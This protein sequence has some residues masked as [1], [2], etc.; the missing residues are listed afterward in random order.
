[1]PFI[2]A[3]LRL[4]RAPNPSALTGSGTNTYIVGQGQVAIIDPG[5]DLPHHLAAILSALGADERIAA[6]LVTHAHL[7]HSPLA[8][9]LGARTGAPVLA[10]GDAAA[11]RSPVMQAFAAIGQTGGGEGIDSQFHPDRIL[12]DTESIQFG[13]NTMR[14]IWTPGHMGNHLCFAWRDVVFSGDHVMGWSSTLISPPDG[15]LDAYMAS[16]DRLEGCNAKTLHP[17]HGDP[18]DTPRDRIT[19]LRIHRQTREHQ[20]LD[21]LTSGPQTIPS[22][23]AQVYKETDPSLHRAA[24]RNV[25]AHL[26]ALHARSHITAKP[27]LR[28]DATFTLSK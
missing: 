15:D 12:H 27:N 17:G 3:D 19:A 28:P 22:L 14:A 25:L 16:L 20:I 10:Y 4:V 13:S 1:M 11:G 6:I 9:R 8:A 26:I 18:I 5:P 23:V 21:A 2:A 7:D 24:A